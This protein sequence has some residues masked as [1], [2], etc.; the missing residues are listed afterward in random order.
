MTQ[1]RILSEF[2]DAL[3]TTGMTINTLS[4]STGELSGDAASGFTFS[5]DATT[6]AEVTLT[7]TLT[8]VDGNAVTD[9]D[10]NSDFSFSFSPVAESVRQASDLHLTQSLLT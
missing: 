10:G 7:A 2:T 9:S 1:T 6:S 3:D 5:P 8:D 4:D